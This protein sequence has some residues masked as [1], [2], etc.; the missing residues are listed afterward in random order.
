MPTVDRRHYLRGTAS[1]GALLVAGCVGSDDDDSGGESNDGED[2]GSGS[3]DYD[4]EIQ[5][6]WAEEGGAGFTLGQVVSTLLHEHSDFGMDVGATSGAANMRRLDQNDYDIGYTNSHVYSLAYDR[7]SPFDDPQIEQDIWQIFGVFDVEYFFIARSDANVETLADF[8]GKNV[9]IYTPS[10]S[11]HLAARDGLENVG[12]YEEMNERQYSVSNVP[13]PFESGEV[14]VAMAYN[15]IGDIT[16]S[17][18]Q[19]LTPQLDDDEFNFVQMTD[20]EAEQMG[21]G[22]NTMIKHTPS[23]YYS[24]T[25]HPEIW[26]SRIGYNQHAP[27]DFPDELMYNFLEELHRLSDEAQEENALAARL[28]TQEGFE[29]LL[30]DYPIHPGA[31]DFYRD[32]G[33]WSDDW[34]EGSR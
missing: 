6:G 4:Q 32:Q 25:D 11:M 22:G 29:L 28:G 30:N 31:A 20:E 5:A 26:A 24:E 8:A 3:G 7:K 17:W 27:P 2:G 18:V 10:A 12:V 33:W 34:T 15:V 19:E 9:T 16:P 1:L 21:T 14:D 13:R 23:G